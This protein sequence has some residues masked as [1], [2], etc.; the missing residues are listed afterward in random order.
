MPT[1]TPE[2]L[3]YP[4]G[5]ACTRIHLYTHTAGVSIRDFIVTTPSHLTP[6]ICFVYHQPFRRPRLSFRNLP[7]SSSPHVRYIYAV[8]MHPYNPALPTFPDRMIRNLRALIHYGASRI[9]GLTLRQANHP[10]PISPQGSLLADPLGV[11]SLT[12]ARS[13]PKNEIEPTIN[14][15]TLPTVVH[16]PDTN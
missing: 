6:I 10:W 8:E 5:L 4:L 3:T 13:P 11:H 2:P 7:H 12:K 15:L 1:P 16:R 9:T 14:P